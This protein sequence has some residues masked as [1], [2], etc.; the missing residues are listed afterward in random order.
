MKSLTRQIDHTQDDVFRPYRGERIVRKEV[1]ELIAGL[2]AE[3][4][5]E[6]NIAL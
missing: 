1:N 2:S 5:L 6:M 3:I 4:H